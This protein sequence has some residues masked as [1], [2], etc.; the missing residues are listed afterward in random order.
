MQQFWCNVVRSVCRHLH[1]LVA[2]D[3]RHTVALHVLDEQVGERQVRVGFFREQVPH[4]LQVVQVVVMQF[5]RHQSRVLRRRDF[6]ERQ[7]ARNR[8]VL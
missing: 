6:A 4:P 3:W 8:V 7:F 5:E 1:C 2:G